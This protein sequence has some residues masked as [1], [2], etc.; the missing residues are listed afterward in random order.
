MA[1]LEKQEASQQQLEEVAVRLHLACGATPSSGAGA[2]SSRPG[3]RRA[4]SSAR[5]ARAAPHSTGRSARGG[6]IVARAD[7]VCARRGRQSN[8]CRARGRGR[9]TA[10]PTQPWLQTA[11]S[12]SASTNFM[13]IRT[14]EMRWPWQR[15]QTWMPP[16]LLLLAKQKSPPLLLP[17]QLLRLR[18]PALLGQTTCARTSACRKTWATTRSS[19]SSFSQRHTHTF[20]SLACS[21]AGPPV[22]G[23]SAAIEGA[24]VFSSCQICALVTC[25]CSPDILQVCVNTWNSSLNRA[26][27]VEHLRLAH[28]KGSM[29]FQSAQ[30]ENARRFLKCVLDG[31]GLPAACTLRSTHP[32]LVSMQSEPRLHSLFLAAVSR[33]ELLWFH[34]SHA[35]QL[36]TRPDKSSTAAAHAGILMELQQTLMQLEGEAASSA[37]TSSASPVDDREPPPLDDNQLALVQFVSVAQPDTTRYPELP[38]LIICNDATVRP[39]CPVPTGFLSASSTLSTSI[40]F[41]SSAASSGRQRKNQTPSSRSLPIASVFASPD[42]FRHILSA[43]A[44]AAAAAGA[45]EE[46]PGTHLAPPSEPAHG[47]LLDSTTSMRN[48]GVR[49]GGRVRNCSRCSTSLAPPA[50]P[51]RSDR[52]L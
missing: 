43:A 12:A 48:I 36:N 14:P 35:E 51:S 42:A 27:L 37:H 47:H 46:A 18:C 50:S 32:V 29:L 33:A 22:K 28:S 24:G 13:Q 20:G 40:A 34:P 17:L 23:A 4:G 10:G 11:D 19:G 6:S 44:A 30:A 49:R 2:Q 25:C 52:F 39:A 15:W 9:T 45:M 21:L 38:M 26:E 3:A 31:K 5:E 8:N 16:M 7:E 41:T 1:Q